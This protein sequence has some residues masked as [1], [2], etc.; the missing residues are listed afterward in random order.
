MYKNFPPHYNTNAFNYK[1]K[2]Q[3]PKTPTKPN[4]TKTNTTSDELFEI[5]GMKIYFDDLLLICILFFLYHSPEIFG[6]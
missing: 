1:Q 2:P 5:L 6:E 3:I 4:I